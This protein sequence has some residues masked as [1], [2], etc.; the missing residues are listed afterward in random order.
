MIGEGRQP[1]LGTAQVRMTG[2]VELKLVARSKTGGPGQVWWKLPAQK[3]FPADSQKVEFQLPAGTDWQQ[4]T[5]TLP[6][7]AETGIVRLYLPAQE[8]PVEIQSMEYSNG[9]MRQR[10]DFSQVIAA[11]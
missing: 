9:E 2:P 8:S 11:E 6:V 3:Q 5:L 1:F 10:W 4:V 7:E